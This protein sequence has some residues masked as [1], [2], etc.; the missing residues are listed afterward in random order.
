MI[1][2]LNSGMSLGVTQI[3]QKSSQAVPV[4]GARPVECDRA[5]NGRFCRR[6]KPNE[7]LVPAPEEAALAAGRPAVAANSVLVPVAPMANREGEL[8]GTCDGTHAHE[9]PMAKCTVCGATG[10]AE[11]MANHRC[12]K[13]AFV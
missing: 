1:S 3:D 7:A 4:G 2:F 11:E 9:H 12:N 6:D 5:A 10:L 13:W 8:C